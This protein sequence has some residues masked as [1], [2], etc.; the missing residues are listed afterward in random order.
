MTEAERYDRVSALFGEALDRPAN[1]REAWLVTACEDERVR[2]EVAAM[3]RHHADAQGVLDTPVLNR[4]ADRDPRL[5]QT[6]GP[7]R[8]MAPLGH[9]GMGAVYRAERADESF[10]QSAALKVVRPGVGRG[11]HERFLRE[12]ALLAGLDHPGIARLLDGGLAND[13]TPYL[14]MEVVEGEPITTHAEEHG[15]DVPDRLVLFLSACEAVAYAHRNLVVH[16]DLKPAHVLVEETRGLG[17]GN[18]KK[19][20]PQ[21]PKPDPRAALGARVKLL[22]FGVAKLLGDED[23]ALTRTGSGPLTPAYAAPEQLLGHPITTA[24]DV[25]ALGVILYELLAGQRPYDLTGQTAAGAERLVAE[26]VPRRPSAVASEPLARRLRGD[27][28]AVVLK[29]LEKAPERRYPS[30]EALADDLRRHLGGLPVQA[31]PATAVYRAGRFVRRHRVGVLATVLVALAVLVGAGVAVASA[32]EAQRAQA[33][34]EAQAEKAEAVA[35]FLE[36]ILRA[37]NARWY[38]DA[39]AKGPDT[40]IRAVMDEAARRVETEFAGQPALRADLHHILGDTYVSLDLYEEAGH[41]HRASLSIRESLYTAPHPDIAEA[42]YYAGS[43]LRPGDALAEL[44]ALERA[45]EM[46]RQRPG[47]NNFPFILQETA[48]FYLLLGRPE[49]ARQVARE[50]VAFVEQ[51]FVPGHDGYRYRDGVLASLNREGARAALDLGDLEDAA[52]WITRA[53]SAAVR[54]GLPMMDQIASVRGR[55]YLARG[56][57]EEAEPL[58]VTG[59]GEEGPLRG[60]IPWVFVSH[61]YGPAVDALA[62]LYEAAGRPELA[63]EQRRDLALYLASRDSLRAVHAAE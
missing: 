33:E 61:R 56:Q 15:L 16:R 8:V 17:L 21:S 55:L 30:A 40:P 7:W 43:Y 20:S 48:D 18:G 38:N 37:P 25:Y 52:R 45:A 35:G 14:A 24:T 3:L 4:E 5:G 46:L 12:R 54:V 36:Q 49:D 6:I 50:G 23:D 47:G 57:I 13:G 51:V 59:R 10:R 2:Q 19:D 44:D 60:G 26:V 42:L 39:E 9:G 58:L 11:F 31:R 29:A 34:A 32:A 28:D 1:A 62:R 53:E 41:H 63:A 27:L 22:D